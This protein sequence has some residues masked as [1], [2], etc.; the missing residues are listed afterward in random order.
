[1]CL[2]LSK[3]FPKNLARSSCQCPTL[4]NPT[5]FINTWLAVRVEQ[6]AIKILNLRCLR[7]YCQAQGRG[8][9]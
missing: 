3:T 4:K 1:V 2:N 8:F 7:L 6:N 9:R 5:T